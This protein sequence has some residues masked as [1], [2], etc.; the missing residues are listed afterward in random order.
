MEIPHVQL[1]RQVQRWW[2][3][4]RGQVP[5]V[6]PF[7]VAC[8]CGTVATGSRAP[9]HQAVPCAACGRMLFVLP[10]SPLPPVREEK[11]QESDKSSTLAKGSAAGWS[12]W[13]L[14]LTAGAATLLVVVLVFALALTWSV[15][16]KPEASTE[17]PEEI[18]RRLE[19]GQQAL[20]QGKFHKA[21]LEL[22]A[23][24]KLREEYPEALPLSERRR[25]NQL[26]RQAAL[27][28]DLL[29]E[30][31]EDVLRHAAEIREVDEEEWRAQFLKRY[32]R[33]SVV[34]DDEVRR[35][36]NG[37]F[38]LAGYRFFVR[39]RPAR[40]ELGDLRLLQALP[41]DKP[42]RLFF[43]A[44]LADV[45]PEAGGTWVVHFE[46]DSAVLITDP[47]AANACCPFP[48]E[49]IRAILNRQ[50]SWLADLP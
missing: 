20:S 29:P 41:L 30:A 17:G 48:P 31:L 32:Q 12:Q 18:G 46:P 45:R 39:G 49:E 26:Y 33:R 2:I 36:A 7:Q 16:L 10:V 8:A 19:A 28:D 35:E 6:V 40:V 24:R 43:G 4:L 47:G 27:L 50:A 14:P 22:D 5:V 1:V 37:S 25:L 13:W 3:D 11:G 38:R 9:V 34:F 42:Q 23:A 44:R 21:V 15:A